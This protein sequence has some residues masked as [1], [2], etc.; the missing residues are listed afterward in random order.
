MPYGLELPAE[1]EFACPYL[2]DKQSRYRGFAVEALPPGAYQRLMDAGFR[3]S[4][5]VLYQPNCRGCRECVPLRVPTR[6]F[7]PSATQ[8]R[9]WRRNADLVVAVGAL[10]VT[11][12]KLELYNRYNTIWHQG[13]ALTRE[14]FAEAFYSSCVETLEIT[15]RDP[16]GQLLA[17]GLCDT[18]P[19]SLSS[20][21]FY[22]APE[23]SARGLGTYGALWELD[24]AARREIPFYYL[25]YWIASCGAMN[26]KAKFGPHELLGL[27]GDWR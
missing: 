26:Y 4:G 13:P 14:S 27:D 15:Y 24:Y 9:C 3:R 19:E 5:Q 2:P 25:G 16:S 21:Y 18:E 7:L 20:V 11:V 8:R 12:E 22:F 17:V 6:G 23:A 1:P 10:E